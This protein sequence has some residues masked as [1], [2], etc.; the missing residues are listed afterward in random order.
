MIRV[1]ASR[2]VIKS[3]GVALV[4]SLAAI[5]FAAGAQDIIAPPSVE[6]L[7]FQTES[8][9]VV[10]TWPSDPREAFAVLWRSNTHWQTPWVVLT[11]QLRATSEAPQT[12]FRDS[13]RL[14][15]QKTANTNLADCYRVFV[16]PDFW[17]QMDRVELS[18]G[19]EHC[20]EDFLPF[21]NGTKET[22]DLFK[23]EIALLADGNGFFAQQAIERIN[24]GTPEKPRWAYSRGLWFPHDG[25][26]NGWH[27]LQLSALLRLNNFVGD[28]S[29]EI[30]MTNKPVRV[31]ISNEVSYIDFPLTIG[32]NFNFVAQSANPRVNWRI[33]VYG[34]R[35][36]LLVSKTGQ[37]T[38]GVIRWSWNLRDTKGELHDSLEK[39]PYLAP[40]ITTWPLDD[41]RTSE[42]HP[43]EK[44]PHAG[45]HDWW[46][47]RLGREFLRKIP[48]PEEAAQHFIHGDD[49]PL[50]KQ[51]PARPFGFLTTPDTNCSAPG[52][53][54]DLGQSY[55]RLER[56]QVTPEYSNAVLAAVLPYVSDV[57]QRLDLPVTQPVTAEHVVH[58]SIM[59]DHTVRAEVG[60]KGGWV[61]GFGSGFV[62]TIQGPHSYY[63]LQD[64]GQIPNYFGDVKMSRS[65]AIQLAANT[66]KKLGISLESVFAE[67]EPR[68]TEPVK[69]GTNIVPHYRIEWLSPAQEVVGAVDIDINGG[70]RRVERI[71]FTANKN[72]ERPPPRIDVV[73][74]RD[75]RFPLWP[76]TNLEYARKLV[77]I[78]FQAIDEY[79]KVLSL[80]VPRPL[81]TN[82][83]ARFSL[84]DNGGWPHCEIELT[85]GWRFIYRNSM[86][87]GYYAPDNFFQCDRRPVL[88]REFAGKP[89]VADEEAIQM[90]RK[91]MRKFNY[92][93]NLVHMDF[94]PGVRRPVLPGIPRLFIFWSTENEDDLQSKVEAEVDLDKGELK[95]LYYDDKAYWKH[96]PP[97]DVPITLPTK[98]ATSQPLSK[99]VG[100]SP[101]KQPPRQRLDHPVPL[102][103]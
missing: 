32:S 98:R 26:S 23:P 63:S 14:A 67:K 42:L 29:W 25:L 87:N 4:G 34:S 99:P 61:F 28:W 92:P 30:T 93:T 22:W 3:R 69:I 88:L 39:D 81:S 35:N 82:H 15:R 80:P 7:R 66:L 40:R 5:V 17:F 68:V 55:A 38:N 76:P 1:C 18:G 47:Q 86:V 43:A 72:L 24:F 89:S 45:D 91:A 84:T 16:I 83:V 62:E 19:P 44:A 36:D 48:S 75:T 50:E 54:I 46:H 64:P 52:M 6:G 71:S 77:P 60:V 57:A 94:Q 79:G 74:P 56:I 70:T 49:N 78:A 2:L 102:S 13:G 12:I 53:V 73:P 58:C 85:N 20:G 33:E 11:N 100:I 8:T 97:I 27:T 31:C 103:R 10:L 65:E 41:E 51:V 101:P 59:P 90:V 37:T 21:Y 95:S 96:P 9:N